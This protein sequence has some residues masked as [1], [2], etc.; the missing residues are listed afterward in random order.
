MSFLDDQKRARRGAKTLLRLILEKDN[1]EKNLD[2][3]TAADGIFDANFLQKLDEARLLAAKIDEPEFA[4]ELDAQPINFKEAFLEHLAQTQRYSLLLA[5]RDSSRD[6]ALKKSVKLLIHALTTKGIKIESRAPKTWMLDVKNEK[7]E[8]INLI[9][10]YDPRGE[11]IVCLSEGLADGLKLIQVIENDTGGIQSFEFLKLSRTKAKAYVDDMGAAIDLMNISSGKIYWFIEQALKRNQSSGR[12]VPVGF[13]TALSN[14]AKPMDIPS[15]HPFF[16]VVRPVD[17]EHPES[18]V[19]RSAEIFHHPLAQYWTIDPPAWKEFRY[20]L[21]QIAPS[22]Q[23]LADPQVLG[24]IN[25]LVVEF[26]AEYCTPAIRSALAQRLLDLAWICTINDER[27]TALLAYAT[28]LALED[29]ATP[30]TDIPFC[31]AL[32]S[33]F[34]DSVN[35]TDQSA[36]K[37]I[38]P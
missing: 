15:R 7:V 25:R 22:E 5:I 31:N 36:P 1:F 21:N 2:D 18:G 11:R 19:A 34:F 24:N 27:E 32:L 13:I 35:K 17:L 20:R 16:D 30:A 4:S 12:K 33:R 14:I 23:S 10:H 6:K 8:P 3:Y 29:N 37:I 26:I 38:V 28:S 9:S